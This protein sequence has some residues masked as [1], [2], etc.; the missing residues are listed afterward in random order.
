MTTLREWAKLDTRWY[1]DPTLLAC[2]DECRN[3]LYLWPLLVAKAKASS[4]VAAN[5]TGEIRIAPRRLAFD[6]Q[7]SI[8]ELTAALEAMQRHGLLVFQTNATEFVVSLTKFEKWQEPR[9]S[10]AERQARYRAKQKAANSRDSNGGV[11][12]SNGALQ[13]VTKDL[14]LDLD[15]DKKETTDLSN[16]ASDDTADSKT[17][18]KPRTD[19]SQQ[20][21][22]VFAYWCK[23]EAATGGQGSKAR[24]GRKPTLTNDRRKVIVARLNEGIDPDTMKK[25]IAFYARDP[26]HVGVNDQG[27]RYTDLTTTLKSGS[28]V[29]QGAGDYE[30]RRA[31]PDAGTGG[32]DEIEEQGY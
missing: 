21:D 16:R 32:V 8:D 4:G 13:K 2:S 7:F 29:E 1:E 20:V 18:R 28:K 22:D 3:A 5:P 24:G 26:Y 9:G 23:V 15:L 11:T 30:Q 19:H 31:G 14:D 6:S 25:A 17:R 12:E 27:R 10:N